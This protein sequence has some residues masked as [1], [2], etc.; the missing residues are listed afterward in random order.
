VAPTTTT[1]TVAPTTT[2]TTVAP[3]TTTTT[4]APTTTTTTVAPT[5]TTTTV[6]PSG[7]HSCPNYD[8]SIDAL[9]STPWVLGVGSVGAEVADAQRILKALAM[10]DGPI[11]GQFG[12]GTRA[13]VRVFQD[14][15]GLT[16]DG[17]V[18]SRTKGEL[19][20]LHSAATSGSIL[21]A[22]GS[23]LR[24]GVSGT[25]VQALQTAL[26]LL[27]FDP[28]PADGQFGP[29]T[30]AAVLLFQAAQNL[31]ADGIIGVQSR[32]ALTHALGH[33]NEGCDG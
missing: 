14:A 4:V 31:T 33:R 16:V 7:G 2:T 15:R 27:G 24:R 1:T 10:Y 18:G 19:A 3:T 29:R 12:Q 32:A 8:F 28:G 30:S 17:V 6:V 26:R 13:A 22:D 25:T 23:L 11:D 20:S 5:T 21:T 9:L